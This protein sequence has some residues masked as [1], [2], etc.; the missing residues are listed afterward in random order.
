M[1][2]FCI[3]N[4]WVSA[5]QRSTHTLKKVHYIPSITRAVYAASPVGMRQW[6]ISASLRLR[7]K[8]QFHFHAPTL[9]TEAWVVLVIVI[10][11][12]IFF[13]LVSRFIGQQLI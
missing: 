4:E 3:P 13:L 1:I 7:E 5:W 10:V 12:R 2:L 6:G 11:F 8:C 9:P